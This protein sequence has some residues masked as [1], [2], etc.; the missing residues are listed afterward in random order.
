MTQ[1]KT[2]YIL[3]AVAAQLASRIAEALAEHAPAAG[4]EK[5]QERVFCIQCGSPNPDASS[6]CC[7]CGVAMP[8]PN[9]AASRVVVQPTQG[10]HPRRLLSEL[11]DRIT[12]F[13]DTAPLEGFSL[14]EMFSE[15]FKN[16][17][18]QE[19]EDYLVVGTSHTTPPLADVAT[20]WPKP[21][22]FVRVL[23]FVVVVYVLFLVSMPYFGNPR[24]IPGFIFIGSLAVPFATLVLFF[25]LNTPRNVSFYSLLMLIS[26]GGILALIA[27]SIVGKFSFLDWMGPPSA[28]VIEEIAKLATVV[29][30]CRQV[31]HKYILNGLLFGAAIGTG[32]AVFES[33]G[34]AQ[35][36]LIGGLAQTGSWDKFFAA[37]G[38]S[39]LNGAIFGR[40]WLSPFGHVVWTAIA[41]GA[42][43]RVK[44]EGAFELRMLDKTFWKTFLVPVACHMIWDSPIAM[45]TANPGVL[46]Y[47][48]TLGL[49]FVSWFVAFGLVQEGLKQVRAMQSQGAIS[50][51][52]AAT[53]A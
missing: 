30:V 50:E 21:W 10:T 26:F 20:G 42:L 43:W 47:A 4:V 23:T 1:Q 44:K 34:Y 14:G 38:A 7:Q 45:G 22:F 3:C 46:N 13:T 2:G 12:E 25:E 28:G 17:S 29:I 49:G 16:R 8:P 52:T 36:A 19:V 18:P 51:Q 41:A 15:V 24:F 35:D 31:K 27:T 37:G 5:E 48:V 40:A 39:F 53:T 6:F 33:A 9:P 11:G 32:F